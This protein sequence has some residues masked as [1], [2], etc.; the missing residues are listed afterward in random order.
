MMFLK[1]YLNSS[2][3]GS[4][5]FFEIR[6]KVD[7]PLCSKDGCCR[8]SNDFFPC[9]PTYK[10]NQFINCGICPSICGH[11]GWA[12]IYNSSLASD[13]NNFSYPCNF[14]YVFDQNGNEL[15]AMC[16]IMNGIS[17][18]HQVN[19]A[20]VPQKVHLSALMTKNQ[21]SYVFHIVSSYNE[22]TSQSDYRVYIGD[23]SN[24]SQ[25]VPNFNVA[26]YGSVCGN[27]IYALDG[28]ISSI[29]RN[30]GVSFAEFRTVFLSTIYAIQP[31]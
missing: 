18:Q 9:D 28:V 8:I 15:S 22:R 14:D 2:L 12:W 13:Q 3:T 16:K 4:Q 26:L 6:S 17:Q 20:K 1:I 31:I 23:D 27:I 7:V 21:T 25:T 29:V 19:V 5:E 11:N 24:N 30:Y 10:R